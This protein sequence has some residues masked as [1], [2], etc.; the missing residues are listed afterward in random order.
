MFIIGDVGKK[1]DDGRMQATPMT[2]RVDFSS[3]SVDGTET[4]Q[5]KVT[6]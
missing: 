5:S 6:I 4:L 3:S 1:L 2:Y